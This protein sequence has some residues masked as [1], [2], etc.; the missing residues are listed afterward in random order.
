[1]SDDPGV[2][3]NRLAK[4]FRQERLGLIKQDRAM[5]KYSGP[6]PQLSAAD[7]L[8]S[9]ELQV[10]AGGGKKTV[11]QL[12]V[13]DMRGAESEIQPPRREGILESSTNLLVGTGYGL[14]QKSFFCLGALTA[15][16]FRVQLDRTCLWSSA[17]CVGGSKQSAGRWAALLAARCTRV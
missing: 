16:K 2:T 8:F 6:T 12:S 10:T 1:M 9:I 15:R 11:M 17:C 13:R 3:I 14:I 7:H 5:L 4:K